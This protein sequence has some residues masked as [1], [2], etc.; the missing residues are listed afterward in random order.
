MLAVKYS[1]SLARATSPREMADPETGW[2]DEQFR[3]Q[4]DRDLEISSIPV[5][6]MVRASLVCLLLAALLASGRIVEI[7]ARQP[8]GEQRDITLDLAQHLDRVANF[9]SLNRPAD[10]I[11]DIRGV[12]NAGET[13][14][15][16]DDLFSA[17]DD[18]GGAVA[19]STT[20]A[21]PAVPLAP[22]D[23]TDTGE[24]P[25]TIAPPKETV[26]ETADPLPPDAPVPPDAAPP[27]PA[28]VPAAPVTVRTIAAIAPLRVFVAG[29]SQADPVASELDS[30]ARSAD[31]PTA[32]HN[33]SRIATGLARPD[34]FN[35]P[36]EL[37]S[38][39]TAEN[40]DVIIMVIGGND[41]Q[42]MQRD[43]EYFVVGT[44]EWAAE[45]EARVALVMDL[46]QS[47]QRRILWINQP[48]L[49]EADDDHA[50]DLIN[51]AIANAASTR[52]WVRV[53]D[54]HTMFGGPDG[55]YVESYTGP[56]GE[57]FDS[58]QDDGV[59]LTRRASRVLA[60]VIDDMLAEWFPVAS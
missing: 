52:P 43:G 60:G 10:L 40:P 51:L 26:A 13:Q 12:D 34:Y 38:V 56:D 29:D 5:G 54:A 19:V 17:V 21:A 11:A 33:G 7:A 15:D 48:P 3:A 58:R 45:Y 23:G 6:S 49:R 47:E 35:W 36:A 14:N 25:T 8:L 50:A 30:A 57:S 27:P 2:S 9:L 1:D 39:A 37:S 59:H 46:V 22:G 42:D 41:A 20:V 31:R 44:A 28:T 18:D 32:V 24:P 4:R 55:S 53:I 16:L